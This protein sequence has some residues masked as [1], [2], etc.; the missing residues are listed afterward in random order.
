[1]ISTGESSISRRKTCRSATLSKINPT[2]T[3]MD[4]NPVLRSKRPA[5]NLLSHGTA[6]KTLR[7]HDI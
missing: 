5:T 2:W 7:M 1:M 6:N 4:A 3:E